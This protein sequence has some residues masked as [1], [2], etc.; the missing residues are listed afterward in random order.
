MPQ[1]VSVPS[2]PIASAP[3]VTAPAQV[4]PSIPVP[5]YSDPAITS[6]LN[7]VSEPIAY[8]PV[9]SP[10][11]SPAQD[12]EE[13]HERQI[14]SVVPSILPS[15]TARVE[16]DVRIIGDEE[17]TKDAAERGAEQD[18]LVF[19]TSAPSPKVDNLVAV[20]EKPGQCAPSSAPSSDTAVEDAYVAAIESS[21]PAA[22]TARPMVLPSVP[23]HVPRRTSQRS[24]EDA[25]PRTRV[26]RESAM[27]G[28]RL[29][30]ERESLPRH[31]INIV[32]SAFDK[33][34]VASTRSYMYNASY[35]ASIDKS[36]QGPLPAPSISVPSL[37]P[38]ITLPIPSSSVTATAWRAPALF[39]APL[40]L[41]PLVLSLDMRTPL[42]AAVMDLEVKLN[43]SALYHEVSRSIASIVSD[44]ATAQSPGAVY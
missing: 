7:A 6:Y 11:T 37:A 38:H 15:A 40:Y 35:D 5:L 19:L 44:M 26:M 27:A 10:R 28:T 2:A 14:S 24:S 9:P 8:T 36:N 21:L 34:R 43:M 39:Q 12:I 17:E 41:S 16:D 42:C 30:D 18:D 3:P 32:V 29:V 33:D 23:Q 4:T 25:E 13:Q 31:N 22:P 1:T 20:E